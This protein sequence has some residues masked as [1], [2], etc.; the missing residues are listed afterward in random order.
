M[1][2][3]IIDLIMTRHTYCIFKHINNALFAQVVIYHLYRFALYKHIQTYYHN[4][5]NLTHNIKQGKDKTKFIPLK[6]NEI[7]NN[8]I[9]LILN[10]NPILSICILMA[11][12]K[13]LCVKFIVRC[14]IIKYCKSYY[15]FFSRHIYKLT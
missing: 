8:C 9:Y 3:L 15:Y 4:I 1:F 12:K 2:I 7:K 13:Y 6:I 11:S 10:P 14:I 5:S